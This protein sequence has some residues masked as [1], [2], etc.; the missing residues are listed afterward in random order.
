[1]RAGTGIRLDLDK[2]PMR[3]EK[4]TP[5]ELMLSESQERMLI[6]ARKGREQDVVDIFHKWELDVAVIGEVASDG[7]V[8]LFWHGEEAAAIPVGP[9]ASEAPVYERPMK[10]PEYLD[11]IE[12]SWERDGSDDADQTDT[13]LNLIATPNLCSKAWIWEQY[14]TTVRTNTLL[15]S[16]QS[17]AA[18]IRIKGTDRGLAM[19][20]DVNPVYCW[21]DPYEGGKQAVA[22]A[23]RNLA[24]SGARPA[25]VTDCLNFGSPERPEIMWQFSEAVRGISE[26]CELLGTPVVSG[27][28]SFY[29]ETEGRAVFPT[30][31]VGMVGILESIEDRM[32]LAF[33]G[34]DLTIVLLGET[35]DELGGSELLQLREPDRAVRGPL[36]DLDVERR[37]IDLI[38]EARRKR[39]ILSAHDLGTGGLAIAIAE[40]CIGGGV[41]AEITLDGHSDDLDSLSILFSESQGRAIVSLREP[42]IAEFLELAENSKIEAR[43]I[44]SPAGEVLRVSRNGKSLINVPVGEMKRI[45]TDAFAELLAGASPEEV[46]R[47]RAGTVDVIAQ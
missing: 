20:S 22:E 12:E 35:R 5:Y 9:I 11:T 21:L 46:I 47:G 25:A 44:G 16:E 40:A 4:M 43:A 14:D 24:C 29:N 13:L 10:R 45:W 3:E 33:S 8:R 34:E 39:L 23:A 37:L 2:V 26:A 38:L 41:G 27:N 7:M 31:T 36:V 32:P 17:D 18:V 19:T 30:P 15:R 6:V 42:R 28:V 1:G